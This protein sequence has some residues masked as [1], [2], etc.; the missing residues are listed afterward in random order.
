MRKYTHEIVVGVSVF[1]A[2]VIAVVSYLYFKEVPLRSERYS[3]NILF[4]NVTGLEQNDPV[5][6]AG[7]RVGRVKEIRLV[8]N[9]VLVRIDVRRTVQLSEDTQA[10]IQSIGMVGEKFVEIS[11]GTSSRLLADGDTLHGIN[12][13]DL[14]SLMPSLNKLVREAYDTLVELRSMVVATLDE[15]TRSNLRKSIHHSAGIAEAV[16]R[17]LN[18]NLGRWNTIVANLEDLS[19]ELT[20]MA[21]ARR[22]EVESTIA[23]LAEGTERANRV[24]ARVDSSLNVVNGILAHVQSGQSSLSNVFYSDELYTRVDS[25]TT[26]IETLLQD[27]KKRP[28]RYL[29]LNFIR[30]F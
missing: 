16:D 26:E 3:V 7:V 24:L 17:T 2:I 4:D 6:I 28:Q 22:T 13:G 10:A 20:A 21:N 27:F 9:K 29:D 18:D 15:E 12:P 30:I 8:G 23:N 14:G 25:I 11:P 19:G 5:A 1:I